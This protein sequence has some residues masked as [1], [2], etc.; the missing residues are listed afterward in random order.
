MPVLTYPYVFANGTIADA[1]QV[2][3]NFNAALAVINGID[4]ANVGPN[5]FMASQIIPS[6]IAQAIFGG[7]FAYTFP[8]GLLVTS[9]L[10][11]GGGMT[12]AGA[13]ILAGTTQLQGAV[14]ITGANTLTVGT[15]Q[16]T[17]GGPLTV[18]GLATFNNATVFTG[19]ANFGNVSITNM[20]SVNGGYTVQA[21]DVGFARGAGQA[22]LFFGTSANYGR[23]DYGLA[24]AGNFSFDAGVNVIGGSLAV[25]NAAGTGAIVSLGVTSP[26]IIDFNLTRASWVTCSSSLQ[27]TANFA[28]AGNAAI[29]GVATS[30]RAGGGTA[31]GTLSPSYG[32][33]GAASTNTLH[34]VFTTVTATT[35]LTGITLSGAAVFSSINYFICI[36]N[37]NTGAYIPAGATTASSVQWPSVSGQSYAVFLYG[38]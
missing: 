31:P 15:G 38:T 6:S 24:Y 4:Y 18:G 36:Y 2:N 27:T 21:G 29:G 25:W 23:L 1:N 9:G 30:V 17:L 34:T 13:A 8:A 19:V 5:G 11:V 22:V 28:T 33:A 10:T 37:I 35:T 7:T 12:V 26:A 16:V 14:S 32:P 20:L 3:S